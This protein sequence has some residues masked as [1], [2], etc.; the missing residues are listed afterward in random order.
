MY[1]QDSPLRTV[2]CFDFDITNGEISNRKEVI[3]LP[4]GMGNPD[5]NTIDEDGMVWIAHFG[6]TC[7]SRWKHHTGQML[8]KLSFLLIMLLR[9]LLE[10]KI[11]MNYISLLLQFYH[12]EKKKFIL[13]HE[14]YLCVNQV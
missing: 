7:V 6:G 10:G 5:G 9:L 12:L 11:W 8:K 1:Y 2:S 13:M 3:S 14:N 4:E